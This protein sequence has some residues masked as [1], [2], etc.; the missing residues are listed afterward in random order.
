VVDSLAGEFVDASLRLLPRGGRF[1]EMGKTDIRDAQTT[2]E[3]YPGVR[4]QAFDLIEAGADRIEQMSAEL[5]GLFDNQTLHRLP[6]KTWDVR[7]AQ[8]AYR[9][10]SQAR[11]IG[12][13]VLTMPASHEE[14]AAGTVL[15]TGGSGMAGAVVARHVV[16][17][18]GAG[19]VVLASRRGEAAEGVSEL[20]TELT[21]AGA[22]VQVVACDVGDRD[23]VV[24]LLASL[25]EQYPLTA[26]IHAAGVLDDA[27]LASLTPQRIDTVLRAKVDAAWNLHE[28]TRDLNL[29]AFVVFSSMAGVVG[30]AGQG[31]YAAANTF[32]D[33]LATHRRAAGLPAV[34]LAWGL[35]EQ[36]SAMTGHLSGRD[37]ARLHRG[38]LAPL[39]APQALELFDTALIADHPAVVATR[40]DP[41]ALR[42]NSAM[43]PPLFSQLVG[44]PSRRLVDNT[45][46]AAS[47]SALAQR[48]HGLDPDE[49]H[50]LLVE[51][52]CGHAATV[53]G[54]SNS[55]DIDPRRAFQDLGFDSLTAV[56]LRNRLKTAT[57]LTLSP[58]VIFDHPT[59]TALT[60]HLHSQFSSVTAEGTDRL[61]RFNEIARELETLVLQPSWN[62]ADKSQLTSRIQTILTD[63]ASLDGHHADQPNDDDIQSAT[64][65]ELFAILD[66]ELSP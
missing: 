61:A 47:K 32:L 52:V 44:S 50:R 35:W 31:N 45:D 46:A 18:Y 22:R 14:F 28:L 51:L 64:E 38:G 13:V 12:K 40:L 19:H 3:Q 4:Y 11:H 56:E 6:V 53:L 34:S 1:I 24:K 66:E 23:A 27:V 9:F 58:T 10:M 25:P 17:R 2:A 62:P 26:V 39:S 65:S 33:G 43:L 63:L 49:Q 55:H 48:L 15:I 41:A 57:G 5:M 59:P 16:H 8:K 29:S 30:T 20:V 36:A 37:L 21:Q 60:R 54:H 7:C 42:A